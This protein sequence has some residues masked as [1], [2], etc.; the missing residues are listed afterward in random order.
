MFTLCILKIS[1]FHHL[2]S[3]F[4]RSNVELFGTVSMLEAL[5]GEFFEIQVYGCRANCTTFKMYWNQQARNIGN[6]EQL[7]S[8]NTTSSCS[9]ESASLRV[10]VT[11]RTE[12]SFLRPPLEQPK[13]RW[14]NDNI[15]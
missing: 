2:P 4:F 12:R 5:F 15:P 1:A 13:L 8:P 14:K 3:D 6:L 10:S 9:K 11:R 7:N